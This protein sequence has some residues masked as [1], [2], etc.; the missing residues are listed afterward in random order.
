MSLADSKEAP[1]V[2]T[3][4]LMIVA[5]NPQKADIPYTTPFSS[6]QGIICSWGVGVLHDEEKANPRDPYLVPV[7]FEFHLI[8]HLSYREKG[9]RM[10]KSCIL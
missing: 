4:T 9:N 5:A 6:I 3:H 2:L 8:R 10:L 1:A 7:Q